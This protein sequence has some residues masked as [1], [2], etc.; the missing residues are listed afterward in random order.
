VPQALSYVG[1]RRVHNFELMAR[2]LLNGDFTFCAA[3]DFNELRVAKIAHRTTLARSAS[4]QALNRIASTRASL[5]QTVLLSRA[6]T[7]FEAFVK[8]IIMRLRLCLIPKK[9]PDVVRWRLERDSANRSLAK[10]N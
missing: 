3:C 6:Q 5:F 8:M 9:I 2:V 7:A 4:R 10:S 1:I